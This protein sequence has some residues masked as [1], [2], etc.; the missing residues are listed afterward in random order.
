MTNGEDKPSAQVLPDLT[1]LSSDEA[2]RILSEAGF[3]EI[4]AAGSYRRWEHGDGSIIFWGPDGR[5]VRTGSE[6][7]VPGKRAYRRRYNQF[8]EQMPF[9][10]GGSNTHDT[11]EKVL[12]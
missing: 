8:G 12:P 9:Q 4:T 6:V 11:G 10:P 5:I 2:G 3:V 7:K 1:G